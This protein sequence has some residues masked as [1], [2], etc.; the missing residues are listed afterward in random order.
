MEYYLLPQQDSVEILPD[1]ISRNEEDLFGMGWVGLKKKKKEILESQHQCSE[2][3]SLKVLVFMLKNETH[4]NS[5]N[6]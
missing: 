2:V 1:Q 4:K 5:V 6:Y 3:R